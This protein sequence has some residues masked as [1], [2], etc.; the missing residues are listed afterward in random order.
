MPQ[1]EKK[2]QKALMK[3]RSKQKVAAKAHAAQKAAA[4]VSLK[5]IVRNAGSYPL[6][7]CWIGSNWQKTNDMGLIQVLVARQQPDGDICFGM[8]LIDKYCLGLKN[9]LAKAGVPRRTFEKE[10]VS[11]IFQGPKPE[12][13]SPELAHQMIYAAIDYAAQF[14]FQPQSDFALTKTCWCHAVS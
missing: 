9:T 2:R 13:C 3:K 7:E 10:V 11:S 1:D 14:G 8:Y 6:L 12:K 5:S 4:T